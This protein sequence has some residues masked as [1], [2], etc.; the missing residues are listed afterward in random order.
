MSGRARED[1]PQVMWGK[2]AALCEWFSDTFN[3]WSEHLHHLRIRRRFRC[4]D[5]H[6]DTS[7]LGLGEYYSVR[8]HVWEASG[9]GVCDGMV[10]IGCLE[11]RLGQRLVPEDFDPDTEC[12]HPEKQMSDRMGSR[13]GEAPSEGGSQRPLPGNGFATPTGTYVHFPN[14]HLDQIRSRIDDARSFLHVD[15]PLRGLLT[16]FQHLDQ[17]LSNGGPVPEQWTLNRNGMAAR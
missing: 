16:D 15:H 17:S 9:L 7:G 10:C 2:L 11:E 12:N 8:D 14:G 6:A 4:V 3:R 1:F 13:I 5:C